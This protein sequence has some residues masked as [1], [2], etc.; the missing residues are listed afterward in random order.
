[1]YSAISSVE[2]FKYFCFSVLICRARFFFPCIRREREANGVHNP[3]PTSI[4]IREDTLEDTPTNGILNLETDDDDF[5]DTQ[6]H[7]EQKTL[8]T[9]EDLPPSYEEVI[10]SSTSNSNPDPE[11]PSYNNVVVSS[12]S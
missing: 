10:L 5:H 11:L 4:V 3:Q 9:D 12:Y 7:Q 2:N 8:V 1:V 6:L